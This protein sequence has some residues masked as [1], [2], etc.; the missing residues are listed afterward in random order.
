MKF[1]RRSVAVLLLFTSMLA[2][3]APQQLTMGIFPYAS[4]SQLV[5]HHKNV[6]KHIN[7]TDEFNL[8]LVT[9][10]DVPTYFKNLKNF[11][12]DLIYSAPHIARFVEKKYGYL[13]VA[14]TSH[15]IRG[16]L[17]TSKNSSIHTVSDLKDKKIS[18]GPTKTILHQIMLKQLK[19]NNIVPGTNIELKVA[20]THSNA[21]FNLVNS[22]SDAAVT[23]IKLWKKLPQ[24]HKQGIREVGLTDPTT[25]FI[26]LA[27][28]GTNPTTIK[29]LRESFL[30]FNQSLA[31]KTYIFK[32]FKPITDEAME[33]L[34]FH[35]RVFE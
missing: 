1:Q 27:K 31:G 22:E 3:A 20:N 33:S 12:Y 19:K 16:V 17:L 8:S 30:S 34:D 28:P 14:M 9:A 6:K 18:M 11:E 24:R 10:T 5:S 32:G 13:R 21:I 15:Q 23:G 7:K 35:A 26:I 4:T 29:K 2:Y 25:G